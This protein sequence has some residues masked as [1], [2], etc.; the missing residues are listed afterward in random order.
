MK[1]LQDKIAIVTGVATLIGV[2]VARAFVDAGARVAILDIDAAAG[3]RAAT[4]L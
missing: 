2:G 3:E 1:G 4:S